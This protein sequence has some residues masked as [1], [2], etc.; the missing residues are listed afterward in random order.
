MSSDRARRS[1]DV[2]RMYRSVVSQQGR[3]T[4]EADANEA[5][6]IRA[7][8]SRIELIHI[9]GPNGAP[10]GGFKISAP[11]SEAHFLD[12][13][14]GQGTL[15]VGGVR[16]HNRDP[17]A[18]YLSQKNRDGTEYAREWADYPADRVHSFPAGA[19][20]AVAKA[21]WEGRMEA[22]Y[23]TVAEQEV[24]AVEDPALREVALGGPD[25]AARTRLVQRVQRF[26]VSANTCDDAFA[27]VV[28]HYATGAVF[29][30]FNM[31]LVSNLRLRADFV[32]T[33]AP[34]DACQPTAQIGFLGPENQLMR[35]QVNDPHTL[36]WGWDNA[37]FL[38]RATVK[39]VKTLQ[40]EGIPVDVYHQPRP[41]QW[42]E[43]LATAVDLRDGARIAAASGKPVRVHAY[44]ATSRLV[45]LEIALPK[46]AVGDS[47]FLRM[48]ENRLTLPASEGTAAELLMANGASTGVRVYLKGVEPV[49]GDYWMIGVRP[50]TPQAILP[51]RLSTWQH[52]DGP[53]RWLAPLAVILWHPKSKS[54]HVTDCRPR[55]E[56]LVDHDEDL[57]F[58]NQ[59]LHGWGVVCG[60][61]VQ[62]MTTD[63]AATHKLEREREWVFVRDGYAIHPSGKD[64]RLRSAADDER[65][66]LDLGSLAVAEKA[67]TRNADG[68]IADGAVSLWIG[69]HGHF[70]ADKYEPKGKL[71][72]QELIQGTMLGDVIDDCI[73]PIIDFIKG[74]VDTSGEKELVGPA[75]KRLIAV[76]NLF[77][78]LVNQTSGAHI[79][80]SE[81]EDL[82]LRELFEG[83]KLLLGG[84]TF[85]AMFDDVAYPAY[86]VYRKDVPDGA[87]R[88]TTIF[89][90]G[91]HQ[92]IRVHPRRPLAFTCGG[93]D[94]KVNVYDLEAGKILA[95]VELPDVLIQDVAFPPPGDDKDVYVI[96][97]TGSAKTDSVFATGTVGDG[98][99]INW[100]GSRIQCP[101]LKLIS[102][103]TSDL[104][105]G[106]VYAAARGKGIVEL[107]LGAPAPTLVA[108]F[109]ATGHLVAAVDSGR[110]GLIAG[111]HESEPNP[112]E[113][114]HLL[115]FDVGS[116]Y[117]SLR[118]S[119]PPD[120]T[121]PGI[122]HDDLAVAKDGT[123]LWLYAIIDGANGSKRLV[124]W[125]TGM[126]AGTAVDVAWMRMET[127]TTELPWT[128][129][130][131]LGPSAGCRIAHSAKSNWAMITYQDTYYGR[132]YVPG[133]AELQN[134]LHPL[135]IGPTSIATDSDGLWFYV[136]EDFSNT[137]TAIPATAYPDPKWR[138]TIDLEAL[139]EY[140]RLALTQFLIV[141]GRFAQ[142]L[143]DCVCE[144]LLI[145]C[146]DGAGKVYLA[147]VSFKDGKIYQICNFH[148]RKYV[149]SF[150]TVEYWM[151]IV[152]VIPMLKWA[153]EKAC[154]SVLA[155]VFDK[156]APQ[157]DVKPKDDVLSVTM[158]RNAL[159]YVNGPE[160][161]QQFAARKSQ[162]SL[163]GSIGKTAVVDKL[164]L[165]NPGILAGPA[166]TTDVANKSVDEAS[167]AA[168]EKGVVVGGTEVASGF[169]IMKAVFSA[170]AAP[171]ETVNLITDANGIVIGM[172]KV[173]PTAP[174]VEAPVP[175]VVAPAGTLEMFVA[176]TPAIEEVASLRRELTAV[177]AA[178]AQ[179][180]TA[181]AEMQKQLAAMAATLETL[182]KP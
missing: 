146:P 65:T 151:S 135:Q 132:A 40:L 100:S 164:K 138:S 171:G 158:A 51:A 126:T 150:P 17:K 156:L 169:D 124:G 66:A 179:Q 173:A 129:V 149:H 55:F 131:N 133:Q 10:D 181:M 3:V 117:G 56:P 61:Q 25:T 97:Y 60:L 87:P 58:H 103:A 81:A 21:D 93:T 90:T 5:E 110:T 18:T 36:L 48:W 13:A 106:T 38:Y 155:G 154:C 111:A 12:F 43:L 182:R 107:K 137:I 31:R 57:A 49:A 34:A 28:K 145:E 63:Y 64:I 75:A 41:Q 99:A 54:A 180:T 168:A 53:G 109:L 148:H 130:V 162:V 9:I 105:P 39:D 102:L 116:Q 141:A 178:N 26:P 78:Q 70:H 98:G 76:L 24:S 95:S 88:P 74:V 42:A 139:Q 8:E 160:V 83:V 134:E 125:S 47:V 152:P 113:F 94:G 14:I 166:T 35:V 4:L 144:H 68:N 172:K 30:P 67:V 32:P 123:A 153:V 121:E 140:R 104:T 82:I 73:K 20:D 157:K 33:T 120:G 22:I 69:K 114:D 175:T 44:D 159:T 128:S 177:T 89:G 176:P 143:K 165:P 7:N 118:L 59:H 6:E 72:W 80:L 37:S 19:A 11:V 79:Y 115:A 71:D 108:P 23:L 112:L 122:G 92:R 147:D 119:L 16:V 46:T 85:C 45:T 1:Y 161:T 101:G 15:Y 50:G 163:L 62:C 29:Q 174:T 91:N 96:G 86:D 142:Y 170:P 127:L 2:E 84:T 136:L 27:E 167:A 77:W 52:P